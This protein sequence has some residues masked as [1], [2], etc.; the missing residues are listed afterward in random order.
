[1]TA[2]VHILCGPAGSGKT[3][4]LL[5]RLRTVVRDAPGSALWLAPTRR[6][7]EGVRQRLLAGLAGLWG[8]RL[9]TLADFV[10]SVLGDNDPLA[11]PLSD[12]QRR[13]VVEEV[14]ADLDGAGQVSHFARVLDTR[15]FAADLLAFLIE[16]ERGGVTPAAFARAA[17]RLGPPSGPVA[18]KINGR[19]ISVK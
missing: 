7:V 17:Y 14:V 10:D 19:S 8:F 1:M 2:A 18:R 13:L 5:E 11:R 9:C 4:R 15:G 3:G 12:V 16:L 6:S